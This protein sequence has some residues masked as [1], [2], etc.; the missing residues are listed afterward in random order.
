MMDKDAYAL[1]ISKANPAQLVVINFEMIVAFLDGGQIDKAK[2]GLDQLIRALNFEIPLA[3]DFYEIYKYIY[4]LLI[5]AQLSTDASKAN[6][7]A[8]EAR[9]LMNTLLEGWKDAEKQV[10]DLPPVTGEPPMVYA[11]LTYSRDGTADEYI[12]D[13]DKKGFMA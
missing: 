2:E 7:A 10:A 3:H 12:D 8:D 6:Q 4:E 11:G 13:G 5:T 1:R 9:E